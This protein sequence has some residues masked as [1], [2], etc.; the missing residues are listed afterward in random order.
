MGKIDQTSFF[1]AAIKEVSEGAGG[2]REYSQDPP[3][4]EAISIT[5]PDIMIPK[6]TY[7]SY[8]TSTGSWWFW[9]LNF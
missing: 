6:G 3:V 1:S 5:L 9:L 8:E 2:P 4:V 7:S